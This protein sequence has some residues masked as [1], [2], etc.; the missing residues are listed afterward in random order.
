[1]IN[2]SLK[3]ESNFDKPI[4]CNNSFLSNKNTNKKRETDDIRHAFR[5]YNICAV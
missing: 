3:L 2:F 4:L 1:M 5:N